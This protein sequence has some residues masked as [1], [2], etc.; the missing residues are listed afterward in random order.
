MRR[1]W[2]A[3]RGR[4]ILI[5]LMN[6]KLR[7]GIDLDGVIIDHRPHKCRLARE[8][9]L[10]LETWQANS[11]VMKQFVPGD[12][13]EAIQEPLYSLLTPAAPPVEGALEFL[14][15][16]R[17]DIFIVSARRPE[18]ISFAQE[19]LRKHGVYDLVPADR[20]FFCG[21]GADKRGYC[22][23]LGLSVFLDDR[24]NFLEMLPPQTRKVLFDQDGV[25]A[26]IRPSDG[27]GV[28]GDWPQFAALLGGE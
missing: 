21:S 27:I 18:T 16:L 26:R 2:T 10:E 23:R 12:V 13:Y 20:V 6:E 8:R 28:A 4:V 7:V 11:N 17:A 14:P 1:R 9:G 19:W 5:M 15:R 24:L 22:E 3:A 25:A